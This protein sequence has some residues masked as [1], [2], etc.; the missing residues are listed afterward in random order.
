MQQDSVFRAY[1]IRGDYPSQINEELAYL[2]GRAVVLFLKTKK[3]IVGRDC[4]N[5]SKDLAQELIR[6]IIEQGADA[7]DIGLCSTPMLTF[8]S[9]DC[10][11]VMVTASHLPAQKNGFKIFKKGVTSIGENNGMQQ[12]KKIVEKNK[13]QE[14]KTKGQLQRSDIIPEY[15][16]HV[17]KFAKNIKKLKVVIDAGNGMAGYILPYI[18]DKLPCDVT[19][20]YF[21]LNGDFPNRNPNPQEKNSLNKLSETVKQQNAGLGAAYDADCDRIVFADEKGQ[22]I[23]PD[24]LLAILAQAIPTRKKETIV[25]ELTCSKTVPET[26]KNLNHT[27]AISKV[28]H[29]F[30]QQTMQKHKAILGGERSGHYFFR[31]NYFADSGDIT[32]ML[33]LSYLSK[34][35]KKL[36]Q[37]TAQLKKYYDAQETIFTENKQDIVKKIAQQFS[38]GKITKLD[39]ITIEFPDWWF[40]IR[41]SNTEPLVRVTVEANSQ[42]LLNSKMKELMQTVQRLDYTERI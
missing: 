40:N 19:K 36:S 22:I 24:I 14:P 1:D 26:I 29:T 2:V 5:S 3:I 34:T 17:L 15:T 30:V 38:G 10:D 11:A 6:G 23:A 21:E 20:L 7:V 39:G 13:F 12:I 9:K 16:S 27:I 18:L 32:L 25:Y 28:G 42:A 8:A 31:D 37:I 4:R 35:N 41:P 33:I